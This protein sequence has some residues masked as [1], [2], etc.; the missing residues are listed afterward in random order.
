[1][2][3]NNPFYFT[4]QKKKKKK[5]Y[6]MDTKGGKPSTSMPMMYGDGAG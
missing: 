2:H 4:N 5:L 1:M 6:I 3:T